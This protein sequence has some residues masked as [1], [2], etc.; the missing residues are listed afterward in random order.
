MRTE[1]WWLTIDRL[2]GS[3]AAK[4]G[5]DSPANLPKLNSRGS[6]WLLERSCG[7]AP[8]IRVTLTTVSGRVESV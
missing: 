3:M 7:L 5:I 2:G 4:A 6:N 8:A 1:P